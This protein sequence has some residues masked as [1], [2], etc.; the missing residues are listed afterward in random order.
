MASSRGN[1]SFCRVFVNKIN[2]L[3]GSRVVGSTRGPLSPAAVV[4]MALGK[5]LKA[6]AYE[7][8]GAGEL[9]YGLIRCPRDD[10]GAQVVK[11]ESVLS[12]VCSCGGRPQ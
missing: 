5:L 9:A 8:A 10:C 11:R 7:S 2:I 12:V 1:I 6:A 4:P 3:D